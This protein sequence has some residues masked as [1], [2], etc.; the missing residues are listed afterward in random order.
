MTSL[1]AIPTFERGTGAESVRPGCG[2]GGRMPPEDGE[3]G[4]LS[5]HPVL[6]ASAPDSCLGHKGGDP[7]TLALGRI[8][9]Y[10]DDLLVA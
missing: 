2:L 3:Q 9:F 1:G 6:H 8:I 10:D 5:E 4:N 7:P